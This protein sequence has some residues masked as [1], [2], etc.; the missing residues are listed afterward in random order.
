MK[1]LTIHLPQASGFVNFTKRNHICEG[2]TENRIAVA[3]RRYIESVQQFNNLVTVFPT[4]LTNSMVHHFEKK[5]QFT[6]TEAEQATPQV[7]F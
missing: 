1:K 6:A 5:P 4:S 3:R 2:K 7:Q